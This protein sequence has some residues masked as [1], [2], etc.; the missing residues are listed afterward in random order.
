MDDKRRKYD[1]KALTKEFLNGPFVTVKE[2]IKWST[3][4]KDIFP[5]EIRPSKD[6]ILKASAKMDWPRLKAKKNGKI[7]EALVDGTVDKQTKDL[8]DEMVKSRTAVNRS[9][10]KM[11]VHYANNPDKVQMRGNLSDVVND[12]KRGLGGMVTKEQQ[13]MLPGTVINNAV[14][15]EDSFRKRLEEMPTRDLQ[16]LQEKTADEIKEI[17]SSI[18]D[19]DLMFLE[20]ED[21]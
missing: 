1:W 20:D 8:I 13:T 18:P 19:E 15:A 21:E 5:D 17:E 14:I 3:K 9:L 4:R 7:V 16:S 10:L 2:Y 11:L 6:S 12:L